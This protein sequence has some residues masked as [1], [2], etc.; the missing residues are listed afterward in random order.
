MK[1]TNKHRHYSNTSNQKLLAVRNES[2]NNKMSKHET[3]KIIK[4]ISKEQLKIE[5]LEAVHRAKPIKK[6]KT[7]ILKKSRFFN[8]APPAAST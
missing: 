1:Y 3:N 7:R 2:I 4:T 6:V 8:L 5:S